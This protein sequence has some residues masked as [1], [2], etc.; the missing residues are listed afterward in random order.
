VLVGDTI[1]WTNK[2]MVPHTVTD[3]NGAFDSG[4]LAPG[5]SWSLVAK[6]PGAYRY[7]C[8]LHPNMQ[9]ALTVKAK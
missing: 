7:L 9:A 1:V 3:T 5:K 2:D 4:E 6:K 8:S